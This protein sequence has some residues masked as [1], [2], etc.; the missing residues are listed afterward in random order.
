[1]MPTMPIKP[2]ESEKQAPAPE[3]IVRDE[4]G[5]SPDVPRPSRALRHG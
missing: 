3:L 2:A 5:E 4:V 1:M